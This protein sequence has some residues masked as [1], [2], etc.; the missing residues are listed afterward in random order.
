MLVELGER[1]EDEAAVDLLDGRCVDGG[2]LYGDDGLLGSG[3]GGW[4]MT[5]C[6]S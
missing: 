4:T 2:G 5:V 3:S 6:I 1:V